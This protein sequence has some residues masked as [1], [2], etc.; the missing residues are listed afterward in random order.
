MAI[1]LVHAAGISAALFDDT[2]EPETSHRQDKARDLF[3]E[4][5]F[6]VQ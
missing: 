4:P 3:D 2:C 6:V 1:L 5:S